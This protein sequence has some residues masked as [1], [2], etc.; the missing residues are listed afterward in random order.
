MEE[1]RR[2]PTEKHRTTPPALPTLLIALLLPCWI[3]CGNKLTPVA[4]V[5]RLDGKPLAA[6]GVALHPVHGGP[7]ASAATDA[8]G[9]YRLETGSKSGVMP[10]EYR[11]SVVKQETSG[12][13]ADKNGLSLGVAP[14]GIK[15]KWIVPP[16]YTDPNTSGL[17][18]SVK[19]GMT[20]V[21]FELKSQP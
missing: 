18:V 9:R 17:S 8:D 14:G 2:F 15:E 21:D 3:G 20:P 13:Q 1:Q 6:A 19:P 7:V 4:G 11:V 12:F 5:V 16:K 10:G